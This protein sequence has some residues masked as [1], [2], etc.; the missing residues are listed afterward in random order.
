MT[1]A[2]TLLFAIVF[3]GAALYFVRTRQLAIA[4]AK[5]NPVP[6][7]RI[8]WVL[9]VSPSFPRECEATATLLRTVAAAMHSPR[10][11]LIATGSG[12]SSSYEPELKLDLA[13][14]RS[15]SS[16]LG[17]R[18]DVFSALE[19]SCQ[20]LP[21]ADASPIFRA[22]EIAIEFVRGLD[23]AGGCRV[24]VST[25]LIDNTSPIFKALLAGKRQKSPPLDNA[26]G[27]EI[28]FCGF[29]QNTGGLGLR[30]DANTLR[31]AW[32]NAFTEPASVKF[33][34]YCTAPKRASR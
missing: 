2:K 9:D 29:A 12:T 15:S 25:D 5:A 6:E 22:V 4:E 14:G 26:N 23:C 33:D 32:R 21:E 19:N 10:I 24:Q 28:S 18:E 17:R 34:P 11:A 27:V 31:E 1:R 20:G 8:A 13:T 7:G 30:T 16:P 3:I